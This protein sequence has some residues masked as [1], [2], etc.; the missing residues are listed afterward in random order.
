MLQHMTPPSINFSYIVK[1]FFLLLCSSALADTS[2][3]TQSSLLLEELLKSNPHQL[4]ELNDPA[5]VDLYRER[6]HIPLWSDEKGRLDRAY[7]LLQI[8]MHAEEEGLEPSDYHLKKIMEYWDSKA[9]KDSAQL[10]LL[11]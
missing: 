6:K 3:L 10:D 7:D 9:P 11:L 8:I 2:W 1:A 5:V 4:Q